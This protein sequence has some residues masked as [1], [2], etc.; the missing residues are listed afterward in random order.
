M[1]EYEIRVLR[2]DGKTSFAIKA[3]H[4][5]D[6]AAVRAGRKMAEGSTFEVWRDLN[7]V[8]GTRHETPPE[9]PQS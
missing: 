7:C 2:P 3:M 1:R 4:L 8:Y 6:N 5:N 9:A